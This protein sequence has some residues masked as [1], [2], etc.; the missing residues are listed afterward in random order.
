MII[1]TIGPHG[2]Q[3]GIRAGNHQLIADEPA[4]VGGSG[5]GPS[6]YDYLLA[7][8]A[9]CTAMTMRMYADRKGWPLEGAEVRVETAR[10]HAADCEGCENTPLPKLALERTIELRG[11]LSDE[12]RARLLQV[13]DRCPVK[14]ALDPRIEVRPA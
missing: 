14:Q 2:Y 13:A 12:Q 6:P 10:S 4:D 3:T 5:S 11:P 9:S 8:V 1:A 7:A